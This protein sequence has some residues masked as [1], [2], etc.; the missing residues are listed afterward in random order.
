MSPT[1]G[2]VTTEAGGDRDVHD[3]A[4][5]ASRPP[6][7]RIGLSARD[8]TEGTVAPASRHVHHR[9]TGTW[10]QT[11]TVTGVDDCDRATA[12]IGYTIVTAAATSADPVYNGVDP[13]ERVGD[14]Q[15][16]RRRRDHREPRP[17]GWHHHRGGRHG[18]V[19]GG[20]RTSRPPTSRS[21]SPARTRPRARVAPRQPHVHA[22][23]L[24]RGADGD[25]DRRGRRD[26]RRRR[27]PTRPSPRR[28]D[29]HRPGVQRAER[30][31]T[32]R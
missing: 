12:T 6:T 1:A 2:L 29:Q 3:G 26:R 23:Q 31:P 19:H 11:V 16:Q 8:P 7:S 20:A 24:E 25:G 22:R 28:G 27:S 4:R 10:P 15:R 18:H 13:A 14:Q 17:P 32:S 30:R 9:R 21:G 5:R